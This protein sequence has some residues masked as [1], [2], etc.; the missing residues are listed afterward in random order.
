[1]AKRNIRTYSGNRLVVLLDGQEVGLLQSVRA[2]DDYAPAP[3]SGIGD[4]HVQEWVP[5]MAHYVLSI[6]SMV[7]IKKN[8]R[9]QG[10]IPEN[11]DA[12]LQGNVFDIVEQSKDSGAVV[13]KYMGCSYASGD[14]EVT[15]HAIVMSS[16]TFNCLDV[17]GTEI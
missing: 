1:M 11:A 5:T 4:I 16:A 2:N 13:R 7:L 6:Q 3:S 9:N 15:K 17:S 14:T 12:V 10:I 8:L